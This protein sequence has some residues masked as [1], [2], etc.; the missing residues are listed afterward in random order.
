[1]KKEK[2][3][4]RIERYMGSI[5]Q[6]TKVM[7]GMQ[8]SKTGNDL[9]RGWVAYYNF[10]RPHTA[11]NGLTPAEAIGID[12]GLNGGNRWEEIIKKAEGNA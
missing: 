8:N 4:N 7:R 6:R 1:M 2:N 9:M 11:L 3:N 5:K 10:L 12:L